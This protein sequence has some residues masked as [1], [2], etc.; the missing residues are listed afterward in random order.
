MVVFLPL[1][2]LASFQQA[3]DA[4]ALTFTLEKDTVAVRVGRWKLRSVSAKE[5]NAFVDLHIKK[6]D[7]NKVIIYGDEAAKYSSFRS[8]L[9]VLKKHDWIKFKLEKTGQK[10]PEAKPKA[11]MEPSVAS[12]RIIHG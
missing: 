3:I 4:T 5:M 2:F 7:P 9:E 1:L 8:I 6:I 10:P 12:A 11:P